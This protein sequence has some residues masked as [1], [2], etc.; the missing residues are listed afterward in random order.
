VNLKRELLAVTRALSDAGVPYALC[1][2]LA[3][4]LHGYPRLTRNTIQVVS[5]PGLIAM[6]RIA[7]RPQDLGD[8]AEL[9]K[10]T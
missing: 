7:G 8:I 1:G 6:K 4:T 2:G 9:E 10:L 3:V 5:R